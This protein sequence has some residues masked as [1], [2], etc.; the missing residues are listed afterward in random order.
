MQN[1]T[2]FGGEEVLVQKRVQNCTGFSGEGVLVRKKILF[3]TEKGLLGENGAEKDTFLHRSGVGRV[4]GKGV[5][6]ICREEKENFEDYDYK[7]D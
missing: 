6:M 4:P 2:G 7:G 1:Y 5:Q 3:Y